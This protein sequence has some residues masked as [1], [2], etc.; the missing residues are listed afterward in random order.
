MPPGTEYLLLALGI[1]IIAF[2]GFAFFIIKTINI[3]KKNRLRKELLVELRD[4]DPDM[5][6]TI[7]FDL[8]DRT[9]L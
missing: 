7:L 1:I 4:K 5:E 2:I 3:D 6:H 8:I 9:I